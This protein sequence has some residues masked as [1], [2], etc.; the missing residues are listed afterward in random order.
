M[1]SYPP[2]TINSRVNAISS[3]EQRIE[4]VSIQSIEGRLEKAVKFMESNK[5]EIM[6]RYLSSQLG[7]QM[8]DKPRVFLISTLYYPGRRVGAPQPSPNLINRDYLSFIKV[9]D[10]EKFTPPSKVTHEKTKTFANIAYYDGND[11]WKFTILRKIAS[12][13]I[14]DSCDSHITMG[15]YRCTE[16]VDYDICKKC[17]SESIHP[18]HKDGLQPTPYIGTL[19]ALNANTL[20]IIAEI[21]L[22]TMETKKIIIR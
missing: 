10:D 9:D 6:K 21:D 2:A 12:R 5:D 7:I 17:Y 8:E 4:C 3:L 16:C 20:N 15:D 19:S 14:C 11:D 22:D 13:H 1:F 18:E